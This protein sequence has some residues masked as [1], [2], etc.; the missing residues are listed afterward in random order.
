[1]AKP[2]R[3]RDTEVRRAIRAFR[4]ATGASDV[5]VTVNSD[6]SFSIRA[7]PSAPAPAEAEEWKLPDEPHAEIRP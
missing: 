3:F 1:M 4:H 7:D 5:V 2:V 6:G